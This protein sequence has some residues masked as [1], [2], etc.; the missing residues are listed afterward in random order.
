MSRDADTAAELAKAVGSFAAIVESEDLHGLAFQHFALCARRAWFH[1]HRIDN[2]H[3]DER[4]ARGQALHDISRPRDHSVEGLLGLSPDRIDWQ[5]RVVYEA[6]GGSGAVNAV[7]RQTAFYALLLW[8]AAGEPWTA[9]T[10]I[11]SA[12]RMRPVPIDRALIDDMHD[13]AEKLRALKCECV[14]PAADRKPVCPACS[15]RFICGYT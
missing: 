12:K 2:A 8:A 9:V 5:N 1:L 13:A 14:P 4:M 11:L 7:S 3:V 15:Y 10:N 6:K